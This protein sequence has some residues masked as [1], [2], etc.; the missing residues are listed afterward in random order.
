M[1][2]LS[3]KPLESVVV[4]GSEGLTRTLK[5]TVLEIMGNRVSLG[6]EGD[7]DIAVNRLEVWTR[8]N[9]ADP[10][11]EPEPETPQSPDHAPSAQAVGARTAA[12]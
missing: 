7:P 1:L 3:R 4:G 12:G 6:F 11:R 10:T 5:I 2:V 9:G 8:R